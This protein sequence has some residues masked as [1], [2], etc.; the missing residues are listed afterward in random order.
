GW[1]A[2]RAAA[3]ARRHREESD[4]PPADAKLASAQYYATH[5]L[6]KTGG[7]ANIV[8]TGAPSVLDYRE[9]WF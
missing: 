5:V 8:Q 6:A 2:V 1:M 7:L 4:V 9:T 3:A